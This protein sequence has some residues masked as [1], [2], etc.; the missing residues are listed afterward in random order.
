[1]CNKD[2]NH[3]LPTIFDEEPRKDSICIGI[4]KASR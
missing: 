4:D 1:M 2:Q 3:P